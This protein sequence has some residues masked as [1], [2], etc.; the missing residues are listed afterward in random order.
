VTNERIKRDYEF[1][2]MRM[3][4]ERRLLEIR[5]ARVMELLSKGHTNQSEIAKLCNVSEPTIS[6]DIAFLEIQACDS[7]RT[8]IQKRLPFLHAKAMTGINDLL[9][10]TND[11]LDN[12]KDPKLRLSTINTLANLY[13]GILTMA[14]DGNIIYGRIFSS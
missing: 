5:R 8:H 7:L 4:G 9:L 10:K 6:R 2:K 3:K 14:S 12:A 1:N 13:A 11:I